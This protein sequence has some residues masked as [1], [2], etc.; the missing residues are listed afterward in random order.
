MII[1]NVAPVF[2]P[3]EG[4]LVYVNEN[5]VLFSNDTGKLGN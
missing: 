4:V 2:P 1:K 3:S 5:D